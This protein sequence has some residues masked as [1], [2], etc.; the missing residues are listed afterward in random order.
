MQRRLQVVVDTLAIRFARRKM[1]HIMRNKI[2][3]HRPS[4]IGHRR[5]ARRD[6]SRWARP[7]LD[8]MHVD[9]KHYPVA[10]R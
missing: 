6:N 7:Y 5:R 4:A 9:R 3:R 1:A 10:A 2:L 8:A